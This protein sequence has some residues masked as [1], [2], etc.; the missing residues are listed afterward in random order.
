LTAHR[1][2]SVGMDELLQEMNAADV[3]PSP[4]GRDEL[5]AFVKNEVDKWAKVVAAIRMSAA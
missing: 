5:V 1:S 2:L 3:E 4:L